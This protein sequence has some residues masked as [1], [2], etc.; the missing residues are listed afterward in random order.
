M[1]IPENNIG[2]LYIYTHKAYMSLSYENTPVRKFTFL[3]IEKLFK[4]CSGI[5]FLYKHAKPL[6]ELE[7]PLGILI[8]SICMDAKQ[9]LY[10]KHIVFTN[11]DGDFEEMKKEIMS[12]CKRYLV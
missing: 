2:F 12:T 8:R 4:I 7:F 10:L 9:V 5:K 11:V 6:E 1:T 3:A